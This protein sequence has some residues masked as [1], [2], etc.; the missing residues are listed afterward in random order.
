MEQQANTP[1]IRQNDKFD[2]IPHATLNLHA[3]DISEDQDMDVTRPARILKSVINGDI[4][5]I[6]RLEEPYPTECYNG[7][8]L[9][10]M[11]QKYHMCQS[12]SKANA[13]K[14]SEPFRVDSETY[15]LLL[16]NYSD[17]YS[18]YTQNVENNVCVCPGGHMDAVCATETTTRCYINVTNPAF[19]KGC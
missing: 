16:S 19:Y 6:N 17:Q 5:T 15:Q 14:A 3:D 7:G 10:K 1:G 12:L 11:A 18:C 8:K 2:L 4:A 9:S 13:G